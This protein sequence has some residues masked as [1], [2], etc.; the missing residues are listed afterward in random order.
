MSTK[1]EPT[2]LASRQTADGIELDLL[3]SSDLAPLAGHFPGLPIVPGVCLLDWVVRHSVRHLSLLG[4][5]APRIQI[6]FRRVIQPECLVTLALHRQSRG[7]VQFEYRTG[8]T[9]YASGTIAPDGP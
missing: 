8:D 6:K 4:E 3:I 1:I 2:V 7:R 5:G 9:V